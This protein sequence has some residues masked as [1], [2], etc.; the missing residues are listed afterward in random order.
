MGAFVLGAFAKGAVGTTVAAKVGDGQEDLRAV[1][2]SL[3]EPLVAQSACLRIQGGVSVSDAR[4]SAF[5]IETV[6]ERIQSR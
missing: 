1:G 4:A 2:E 5:K 3:A 6:D